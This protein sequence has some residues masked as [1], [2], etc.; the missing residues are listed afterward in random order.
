MLPCGSGYWIG[1]NRWGDAMWAALGW[2]TA[3]WLACHP[4][5]DCGVDT[6]EIGVATSCALPDGRRYDVVPAA[7]SEASPVILAFHGGG[8]NAAGGRSTTC[9]DGDPDDGDA[10]DCLD[11]LGQREGFLTVYPEGTSARLLPNRRTWNAGGG[12]GDF[13]CVS[14]RA[15]AEGVDDI[16]Y[17]EA[18][19]DDLDRW[20]AVDSQRVFATGLSN[21]GAMTYRVGRELSARIAAIAPVASGDQLGVATSAS[22]PERPVPV[23]HLHGT[24]DPCWSFDGGPAACL[25]DDG[26]RKVSVAETMALIRSERGCSAE[27]ASEALPDVA[28]DGTTSHIDRFQGCSADVELVTIDGGGHTW[29]SGQPYLSE[30]VIGR[31]SQDFSANERMWQFFATHPLSE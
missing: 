1:A 23:L 7:T 3:L 24:D 21:G 28:D 14:G 18:V 9:R 27:V 31:V 26:K 11:G 15:C 2:W 29:P 10:S 6:P 20:T 12:V 8:G 13:Q 19:L 25:Q 16:A 30:R 17:V 4:A 5:Q 22:P